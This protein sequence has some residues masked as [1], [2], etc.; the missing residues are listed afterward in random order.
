MH[1]QVTTTLTPTEKV[2]KADDIVDSK[3]QA[4]IQKRIEKEDRIS[5]RSNT[6]TIAILFLSVIG[7]IS[8]GLFLKR[9]I[10][11][12]VLKLMDAA[13]EIGRGKLD[14]RF[15]SIQKMKSVNWLI[16]LKKWRKSCNNQEINLFQPKNTSTILSAL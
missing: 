12:P 9:S 15:I 14:T 16:L 5:K 11:R 13:I 6:I 2:D 4:F 8:I 1:I 10:S 7:C 3:M